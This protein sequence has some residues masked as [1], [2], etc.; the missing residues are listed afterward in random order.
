MGFPVSDP[1]R[2]ALVAAAAPTPGTVAASGFVVP[3]SNK[4]LGDFRNLDCTNLDAGAS[5][6]AGTVDVFPTTASKGKLQIT[7][8]DQTGD[9]TVTL[10]AGA[11]AAARAYTI[12]DPLASCQFLMGRQASLAV[13]ANADGLTTAIIPDFGGFQYVSVT[14]ANSA[15]LVTLPTPT[16]GT[17]IWI[18][19]GAN[20]CKIR[21]SAPA[22]IAINGGTG[23]SVS[24]TLAANETAMLWCLSATAWKGFKFDADSDG[25]KVPAAA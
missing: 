23:A 21:S 7:C 15:H 6:T 9:T 12:A 19:V 16:P 5:G 25:A 8:T 22:S 24:S 18:D 17:I 13:T 11:A 2:A 14:S 10:T 4:D 20:G 3:D 1:I